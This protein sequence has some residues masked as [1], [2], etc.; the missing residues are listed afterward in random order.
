[1]NP[2]CTTPVAMY[3]HRC[4]ESFKLFSLVELGIP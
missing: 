4:L 1:V 2:T 3:V